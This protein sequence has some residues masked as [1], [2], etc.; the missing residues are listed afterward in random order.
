MKYPKF[1]AVHFNNG[2][3]GFGYEEEQ[4]DQHL[5]RTVWRLRELTP[6]AVWM[7]ANSTPVRKKDNLSEFQKR[8][9]RVLV[10]NQAMAALAR[11]NGLPLTDL[12]AEM[13]NH[14]EYYSPDGT[15]F[16]ETGIEAQA[17][18]VAARI[19]ETLNV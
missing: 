16:N 18:L 4:Y 5:Q 12:Y 15:H 2:L 3:H 17:R 6:D 7:L 11:K 19:R 9:D 10:R 14:P 8:N 13:E 1:D